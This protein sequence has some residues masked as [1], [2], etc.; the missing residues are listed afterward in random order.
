MRTV[1]PATR[2]LIP[3]LTLIVAAEAATLAAGLSGSDTRGF[4]WL[5]A[6]LV[7]GFSLSGSV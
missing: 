5:L 6:A 3:G 2:L 1:A 7:A 4:T